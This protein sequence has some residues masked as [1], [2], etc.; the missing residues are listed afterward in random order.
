MLV[1]IKVD[2]GAKAYPGHPGEWLTVGL[3]GLHQRLVVYREMG[4]SFA[5]WRAVFTIAND[6]PSQDCIRANALALARYAAECQAEGLVPIVEP[7]IVM[8]G[9]HSLATTATVLTSV[10]Q[11]LFE[12]LAEERVLLEGIILK[13]AMVLPGASAIEQA[14]VDDVADATLKCLIK[15]VPAAVPAI[16]FLSGG[17]DGDLATARLRAMNSRKSDVTWAL[18]FSFGRAIQQP[19]LSIWAGELNRLKAAQTALLKR[20]EANT[21]AREGAVEA[22]IE[23]RPAA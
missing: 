16:A 1:G 9:A 6:Q 10:L 18:S 19:A 12:E 21:M 5:K 7:E 2:E 15:T 23:A 14:T 8:K 22:G 3:D 4:A 11:I 17:Q 20:A 13:P